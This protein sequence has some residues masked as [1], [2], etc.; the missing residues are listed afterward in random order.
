LVNENF[1]FLGISLSAFGGCTYILHTLRGEVRPNR[2]TW[3]MWAIAPLVGFAA[4]LSEGVGIKALTTFIVGFMPALIF[5]ASFFNPNAE[6][7]LGR[8]DIVCGALSALGLLLWAITS[9]A[10]VAILFAIV[11]DFLAAIPTLRKAY[12]NP[13]TESDTLFWFGVVNAG[14]GLLILDTWGFEDYAFAL[15]LLVFNL[16]IA[17]IIRT[18]VGTRSRVEASAG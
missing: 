3:L 16:C 2:V 14:I 18:K 15:Y 5:I 13:E 4:Q 12:S 10:N 7:R 11:A 8:F 1:V 9:D 17:T 6:W